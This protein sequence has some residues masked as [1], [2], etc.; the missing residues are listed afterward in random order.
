MR[1]LLV[2][3]L[4]VICL[5]PL[6]FCQQ[7]DEFPEPR[8]TANADGTPGPVLK[9]SWV[10]DKEDPIDD[11]SIRTL[12][13]I[14]GRKQGMALTMDVYVPRKNR[15]GVAI[16]YVFSGGYWSGP[17]YR[18]TPNSTDNVR[19]LVGSGFTVFVTLHSSIPRFS[20]EDMEDDIHRSIKF[21]RH[22]HQEYGINPDK[23]GLFGH[24]S[25]GHLVLLAGTRPIQAEQDASDPVERESSE[26]QAVVAIAPPT[27]LINIGGDGKLVTDRHRELGIANQAAFDFK[28]YDKKEGMLKSIANNRLPH[29]L[30]QLSPLY[31]VSAN[32]PPALLVHGALDELVRVQQS[33]S[34]VEKMKENGARAELLLVPEKGHE[35][36]P[37]AN[38]DIVAFFKQQ[39]VDE[40]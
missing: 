9:K 22:H 36:L 28:R 14:Y 15:N 38:G 17:E 4:S 7:N 27:D 20:I 3:S 32:S 11:L 1:S 8:L 2:F 33:E 39:L 16:N 18:M 37:S 26:V 34:F 25:G 23:L 24:S 21:I 19:N 31:H 10:G 40:P 35:A 30:R 12:N 29:K 5:T 6:A 13:V